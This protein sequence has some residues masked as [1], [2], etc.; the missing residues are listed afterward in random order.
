MPVQK[1]VSLIKAL[2][3]LTLVLLNTGK[4]HNKIQHNKS[5]QQKNILN[6]SPLTTSDI[7]VTETQTDSEKIDISKTH[8]ESNTEKIFNTDALYIQN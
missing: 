8:T 6:L 3:S 4:T 7:Q 1:W 2:I 5:K